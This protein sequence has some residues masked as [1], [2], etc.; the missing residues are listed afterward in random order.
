VRL[1]FIVGAVL[2]WPGFGYAQQEATLSGIVTD[3]TDLVLP[4]VSVRAVHLAT[5]NSFEAVTDERGSYRIPVRAGAY[6]VTVELSGFDTVTRRV[7][8]LVGQEAVTSMEMALSGLTETLTV[9]GEA[10]LVDVTKSA[11]GGN[12]DPKQMQSLPVSGRNWQDLAVLAPGSQATGAGRPVARERTD[13]QLNMDGVQVTNNTTSG[14]NA[15]FSLD[16]VAEFKFLSGRFDATQGRASGVQLQAIS[17]SGTN[18]FS[19]SAG[20]YIRDDRFN[21]ADPVAKRVIPDKN[22]QVSLTFGGPL[23]RNKVHFFGNYEYGRTPSTIVYTSPYPRFNVDQENNRWQHNGGVRLDMELTSRARLMA[24]GYGWSEVNPFSVAGSGTAHP[25]SQGSVRNHAEGLILSWTQVFSNR[26]VNEL[27]GGHTRVYTSPSPVVYWPNHPQFEASGGYGTPRF[28]LR[29]YTIGHSNT[30]WPFKLQQ[31]SRPFLRDDFSYSAGSHQVRLGGEFYPHSYWL[32]N[33]R[34]CAGVYDAQGGPIPANIEDLF[35]VWDDVSTWNLNALNPIIRSYQIG[36]GDFRG[37]VPRKTFATW[38]QDDWSISR[39]LT[40][41]VGLRYD[42]ELDG[43]S[44]WVEVPNILEADRPNDLN[45]IAP[46]LGFAYTLADLTVLRGG[47]GAYFGTINNTQGSFTLSARDVFIAQVLND[48][49]P[50]FA[51]NPFNGPIPTYDQLLARW[52]GGGPVRT[53]AGAIAAPDMQ[54]PVSYHGSIGFQRQLGTTI[55]IEAD[56]TFKLTRHESY[57]DNNTNLTYDPVTGVNYPFTDVARRQIVGWG[58]VQMLSMN[59]T[60]DYHALQ[61]AFT[62]RFSNN[63]QGSAT[64]TLSRLSDCDPLPRSGLEIVTFDVAPDL[65]GECS[66]ATSDQRHRAVFNGIWEMPFG[67]QTS[68][69]YYYGSGE[70]YATSYGGD[71]RGRGSATTPGRLRPDGTIVPRND[72]VGKPIHRMDVRMQRRFA[73]GGSTVLDAAVDVF[74]VFNHANYGSYTTQES[75]ANYGR[76]EQ[77]NLTAHAPRTLQLG[78]KVS[79]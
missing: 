57:T 37:D 74:N 29:S 15:V 75:S 21:A 31:T 69:L 1:I 48:G 50:D 23:K 39:R 79:F 5:G 58:V 66:L 36:I 6:E 44:N 49:R 17:K 67:F 32:F 19:G 34:N 59:A 16:A 33:C 56:Y 60:S 47:W 78:V 8:L 26:V 76:P 41:N 55:G 38:I 43:W 20:S 11:L 9:T 27:K 24:R 10:P 28:S 25:S 13:Y 52:E 2:A 73:L 14:N 71:L 4:G 18:I 30:N 42:V 63:W 45:N 64:Y 12:V 35:P 68:G 77:S 3:S 46:R 7:E 51:T 62:K 40:L 72:F 54:Q 70:R 65:G 61:T 22:Q 53:T